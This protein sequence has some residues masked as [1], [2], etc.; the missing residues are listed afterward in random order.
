MLLP[1]DVQQ[2]RLERF[3]F[4]LLYGLH[5]MYQ[6]LRKGSLNLK[7]VLNLLVYP[8]L[9]HHADTDYQN[10]FAAHLIETAAFL[11]LLIVDF[12][13]Q[14]LRLQTPFGV[15]AHPNAWH[16]PIWHYL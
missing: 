4:V 7:F 8:N 9:L 11:Y 16:Q 6:G 3:H 10:P 5:E 12:Q 13:V 1:D 2:I 14:A 15:K